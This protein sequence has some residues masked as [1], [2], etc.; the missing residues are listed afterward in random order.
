MKQLRFGAA[1][2]FI[3]DLDRMGY[4]E[5]TELK[6]P[7]TLIREI[8]HW[9]HEFQDTFCEDYPPDSGFDSL[10]RKTQHNNRGADLAHLIQKELGG[11]VLVRFI[12]LKQFF[13]GK[14]GLAQ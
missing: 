1:P 5:L 11:E 7:P 3:P 8:D 14:G 13:E 2:I 6:L 9:N 12:P 10:E 4:I